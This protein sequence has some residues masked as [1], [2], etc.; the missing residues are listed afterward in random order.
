MVGDGQVKVDPHA[1]LE[2]F[3]SECSHA[4]CVA[5]PFTLKEPEGKRKK[6]G[7]LLLIYRGTLSNRRFRREKMTL[8]QR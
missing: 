5:M 4:K 2:R 6:P 3:L 7:L 8:S 1:R